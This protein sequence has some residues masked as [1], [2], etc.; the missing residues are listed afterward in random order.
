MKITIE[1]LLTRFFQEHPEDATPFL[2]GEKEVIGIRLLPA[3]PTKLESDYLYVSDNVSKSVIESIPDNVSV[4]LFSSHKGSVSFPEAKSNVIILNQPFELAHGFNDLQQAAN[5]FLA[6]GRALD[7]SVFK[8]DGFQE[9]IDISSQIIASAML[10]YDPALKLLAWSKNQEK[11][12]NKIFQN[13]IK[14][15]Y[16]DINS[17][18]YFEQKRDFEKIHEEGSSFGEVD[19]IREHADYIRAININQQLTVYCVLLFTDSLPCSYERQL[20]DI[21]CD[22]FYQL[23]Q[24][25]HSTFIRDRSVTDY[26]L[27]DILDNPETSEEQIR[28][29]LLYLDLDYE[30]NYILLSIHSEVRKKTAE[31]FFLQ[32]IRNNMIHCQTFSYKNC[33]ILLIRL[34]KSE[35]LS[36]RTFISGQTAPILHE[37]SNNHPMI[38]I[39]KPFES[40]LQFAG[41]YRQTENTRSIVTADLTDTDYHSDHA[42]LQKNPNETF[43]QPNILQLTLKQAAP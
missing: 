14:N 17:V 43:G 10:V 16:M 33:I 9:L 27:M 28:E 4:V 34:P 15:G 13:A 39:S 31:Q 5:S 41:A 30:D 18:R 40:I 42:I 24:N 36:Y 6:W 19:A 37:F 22:S 32:Y 3:D 21:L 12:N 2:G 11:L 35:L 1:M 38:F 20:F 29:R 23:L 26:F 25:R 7:F 8:G